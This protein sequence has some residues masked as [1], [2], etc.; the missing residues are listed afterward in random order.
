MSEQISKA[1][2]KEF[3][4]GFSRA[5]K[6]VTCEVEIEAL[7]IFDKVEAEWMPLRGIS[8]DPKNDVV[9]VFFDNLDHMIEKPQQIEVNKVASGVESLEIVSGE[10]AART[11][12]KLKNP[13]SV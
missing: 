5:M 11:V 6:D 13:V 3:L 12:I 8:Y 7:G 1:E 4:D 9:S 2:W 10:D